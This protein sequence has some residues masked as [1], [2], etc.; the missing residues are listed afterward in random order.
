MKK[1]IKIALLLA[2]MTL[3]LFVLAGCGGDKLV[4]TKSTDDYMGKYEEKVEVT[5]KDDKVSEIKMTYTF[6]DEE[7]AKSMKDMYSM[8]TAMDGE[9]GAEALKGMDVQQDG[10]KVVIT[11]DAKAFAE[12]EGAKEEEMTKD[13]IKAELEEA[14]YTVK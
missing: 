10:K 1:T 4:A 13:A 5:F 7:N 3:A 11:M 6:E 14:G 12:S 8:F 2:L 9:E